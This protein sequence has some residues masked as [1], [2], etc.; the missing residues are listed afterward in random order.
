MSKNDM[1]CDLCSKT[2]GHVTRI[3]KQ[4]H[5][6]YKFYN[7]CDECYEEHERS[8]ERTRNNYSA[9]VNAYYKES[10]DEFKLTNNDLHKIIDDA[11]ERGDRQVHIYIMKDN[12]SI[13]V[14]PASEDDGMKWIEEKVIDP[15][16]YDPFT[17]RCSVCGYKIHNETPHYCPDCG[18]E[19]TGVILVEKEKND[20]QN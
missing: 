14:R 12:V 11:M 8:L 16:Y 2:V 9:Q 17:F 6:T 3:E 10:T 13:S 19:R 1:I 7:L 15:G 18:A 4:V 20:D 5:G